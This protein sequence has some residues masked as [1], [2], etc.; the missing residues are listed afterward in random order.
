[1]Y[2]QDINLLTGGYSR[3]TRQTRSR[4]T[5]QTRTRQHRQ[6]RPRQSNYYLDNTDDI[7]RFRKAHPDIIDIKINKL[8]RRNKSK[9]KKKMEE[10]KKKIKILEGFKKENIKKLPFNERMEYKF[11]RLV[12]NKTRKTNIL[13]N[14]R[15][16]M[17]QRLARSVRYAPSITIV[18]N[19]QT[20]TI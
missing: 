15:N 18:P 13:R 2:S 4:Q 1:M 10:L 11:N 12:G 14:N 6:T 9:N 20:V 17:T 7:D 5:R 16:N 19:R 8:K 3:Q